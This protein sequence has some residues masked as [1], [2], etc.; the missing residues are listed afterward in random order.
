MNAHHEHEFEAAPGL[1]EPLPPG[2]RLLWQGRPGVWMLAVHAFHVRKVAVY[3]ALM[4]GLQALLLAGEPEGLT[5]RPL[6]TSLVMASAGLALLFGTA[7]WSASTALYTV[8]D[9]RIVMRIGIVLTLTFNLPLRLVSAADVKVWSGGHGDISLSM[10]GWD[11]IGYLHLWPHARA[12]E[13][14]RPQPTLRCVPDAA[15]VAGLIHE[16]WRKV[17]PQADTVQTAQSAQAAQPLAVPAAEPAT[18][19]TPARERERKVVPIDTVTA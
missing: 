10:A 12:W 3:F 16:A 13:L 8:T 5:A 14:R 6:I 4:L 1:P 11:R 7:W 19:P 15:A 9:R 18:M 2:E 17:H